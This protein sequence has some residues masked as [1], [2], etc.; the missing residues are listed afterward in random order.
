M[1]EDRT[2]EKSRHGIVLRCKICIRLSHDAIVEG[3]LQRMKIMDLCSK[4]GPGDQAIMK[5]GSDQEVLGP[6]QSTVK[7]VEFTLKRTF[8]ENLLDVNISLVSLY[9]FHS[10]RFLRQLTSCAKEFKAYMSELASTIRTAAAEVAKELVLTP[11]IKSGHMKERKNRKISATLVKEL[12]VQLK[13]D[14]PLVVLPTSSSFIEGIKNSIWNNNASDDSKSTKSVFFESFAIGLDVQNGSVRFVDDVDEDRSLIEILFKEVYLFHQSKDSINKGNVRTTVSSDY[15]N[16]EKSG[17]EPL[18]EVWPFTMA[19]DVKTDRQGKDGIIHRLI[20]TSRKGGLQL[21]S[22][23]TINFNVTNMSL[24]LYRYM[25]EKWDAVD[26]ESPDSVGI[27]SMTSSPVSL[28]VNPQQKAE[29]IPASEWKFVME[30][31]CVGVSLVNRLN[32]ELLYITLS[33]M[34]LEYLKTDAKHSMNCSIRD[35]QVDNQL[36]EHCKDVALHPLLVDSTDL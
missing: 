20:G 34:V 2:G 6:G 27:H 30:V 16:Q 31:Q 4:D 15:F 14:N 33:C 9:Y 18:V 12:R 24:D 7:A 8:A 1:F 28:L 29:V 10:P 32:E 26:I 19:W 21:I 23:D 22:N 5:I 36:R 17:W 13:A 3:S 25:K 11:N 35:M